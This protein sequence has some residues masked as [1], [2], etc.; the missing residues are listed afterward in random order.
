MGKKISPL[1]CSSNRPG[2]PVHFRLKAYGEFQN[3]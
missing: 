1:D 2:D 3:S